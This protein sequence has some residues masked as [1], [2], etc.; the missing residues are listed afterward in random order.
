M[1]A[2][3]ASNTIRPFRPVLRARIPVNNHDSLLDFF[4]RNPENCL[5]TLVLTV[6]RSVCQCG[7]GCWAVATYPRPEVENGNPRR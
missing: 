2:L 6:N 5:R 3:G 1:G 4:P 7:S